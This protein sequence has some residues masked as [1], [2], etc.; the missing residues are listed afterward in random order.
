MM[1]NLKYSPMSGSGMMGM[2]MGGFDYSIEGDEIGGMMDEQFG[3]EVSAE[4]PVTADE[5]V[6]V[7]QEYLDVFLP[8]AEADEHADAFYGYYTLHINRDGK[9]IGMLSVNGYSR[10]VFL[11]TWHGDLIEMSGEE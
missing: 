8:G 2:M 11:H 4:M 3:D 1:W 5:A 6:R 7:A 9:T 10:S